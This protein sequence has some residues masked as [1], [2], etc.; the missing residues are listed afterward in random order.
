EAAEG[1]VPS[2][3]LVEHERQRRLLRMRRAPLRAPDVLAGAHA[4][5]RLHH[6]AVLEAVGREQSPAALGR[7]PVDGGRRAQSRARSREGR[8]GGRVAKRD[9]S[10]GG[11]LDHELGDDE[12]AFRVAPRPALWQLVEGPGLEAESGHA[13]EGRLEADRVSVPRRLRSGGGGGDE[14]EVVTLDQQPSAVRGRRRDRLEDR[15]AITALAGEGLLPAL[16]GGVERR[17]TLLELLAEE[18]ALG[19][20]LCGPRERKAG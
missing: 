8:R 5:R 16:M 12:A 18:R 7:A 10:T 6:Q 19:G 13:L 4:L 15:P 14:R 9:L 17:G 1:A 20:R 11:V 3:V 2:R